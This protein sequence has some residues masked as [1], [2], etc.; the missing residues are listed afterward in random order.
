MTVK[1]PL[2]IC[3][4]TDDK[5]GHKNQLLGLEQSLAMQTAITSQWLSSAE[6]SIS[7]WQVLLRQAPVDLPEQPDVVV[8][9]GS[10]AQTLALALKRKYGAFLVLLMRPNIMP[11]GC[12]DALIIPEHDNPPA[13][14]NV[15]K[16]VGV[17]NKVRPSKSREL[18]RKGLMLIGGES[19]HYH[20]DSADVMAQ[21]KKL[22]DSDQ[23]VDH[24]VIADSRRTPSDLRAMLKR[25]LDQNSHFYPHEETDQHWLPQQMA[26]VDSIWVTPDSVSMVY[27]ALTSGKPTG[28][29]KLSP[30]KSGR[31]VQGTMTLVKQNK[32][33]DIDHMEK[34]VLDASGLCEADRA[35]GWLLK[36]Y[37][38]CTWDEG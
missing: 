12:F 38:S 34:S 15:L 14:A 23:T 1:K 35:A 5:P 27:E 24:W 3:F 18:T 16:T 7:W 28:L 31:I 22:I 6:E 11:Y 19:K 33:M 2:K 29:F 8:A 32:V 25:E 17:L 20:W 30:Q 26:E 10:T 36:K 9:A 13:R 37:N 21:M 4:V